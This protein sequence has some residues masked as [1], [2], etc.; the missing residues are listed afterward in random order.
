MEN[1]FQLAIVYRQT[2]RDMFIPNAFS[3]TDILPENERV[4]KIT[5]KCKELKVL[6]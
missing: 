1:L 6:R 5:Q 4:I 2:L 3:R